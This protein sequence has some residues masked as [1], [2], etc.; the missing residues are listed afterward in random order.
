MGTDEAEIS[1]GGQTDPVQS[2][3]SEW[4]VTE[5]PGRNRSDC[6]TEAGKDDS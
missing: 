4:N 6:H 1:D 2:D 3:D 5:P